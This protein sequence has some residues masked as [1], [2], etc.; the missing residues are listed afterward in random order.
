MRRASIRVVSD[1]VASDRTTAPRA[2]GPAA[3][4]LPRAVAL[5]AL[6]L[7]ALA[8]MHPPAAA[9][10]PVP[11]SVQRTLTPAER[12]IFYREPFGEHPPLGLRD[13]ISQRIA[14]GGTVHLN[15]V[16]ILGDFSDRPANLVAYPP[17][18][19]DSLLFSHGVY[20]TG[21]M[22]DYYAENS[23]GR[24]VLD[25]RVLGWYRMPL[26]YEQYVAGVAG[27]GVYPFNSQGFVEDAVR[28][29]DPVVNY[30]LYDNDGGDGV[31][32]TG[33]DDTMIDLL[34][35]IHAGSGG[36]SG[37][38]AT[39]LQ[40]IA[41]GLPNPTPFDGVFANNFAIAPE[42]AHLGVYAHET[43][44][45]LGLPD[46]YDLTGNSF[47]LG[48][49]S[50]MAGGW[51]LD[52]ARTP[53]QLDA[54]SKNLLRFNP[55]VNLPVS[56]DDQVL[57]PVERGGRIFRAWT[58]GQVG[59][60]YFLVE[61]RRRIG[62]DRF[63]P[64][65]GLL[66]YHVNEQR[67]TNNVPFQYHVALEQADGLFQLENAGHG[68]SFGDDGDPWTPDSPSGGFGRFTE[69]G[70]RTSDGFDTGVTIYHIRGPE[71]DGRMRADFRVSA[72]ATLGL[73]GID[74]P[75]VEGNGDNLITAG[76]S[77]EI[78]PRLNI[79]G[80]TAH[81]VVM[82]IATSDP[83]ASLASRTLELGDL[84]PGVHQS[85]GGFN[86]RVGSGAPQNP[87][88]MNFT[89]KINYRDEVALARPLSVAI[90]DSVGLVDT[91]ENGLNGWT[92]ESPRQ[93][94]FDLWRLELSGGNPASPGGK[95]RAWHC[96][97]TTMGFPGS[98]DAALTSPLFILPPAP[99]LLF[100]QLVEIPAGDSNQVVAGGFVE[101]SINGSNWQLITP[102]GG[103]DRTYFGRD[104]TLNRTPVFTG[105]HGTPPAWERADFNL[106]P[107]AGGVRLRFRFFAVATIFIGK[108]WWL[109][110]LA[111]V[112]GETPLRL[113]AFTATREVA[114]VRLGWR[115][116]GEERPVGY[117]ILR[118][119]T[120]GGLE[121]RVNATLI[122]GTAREFVDA[123]PPAGGAIY[124]LEAVERGGARVYLGTLAVAGGARPPA[125]RLACAPNPAPGA[126]RLTFELAE[127]GPARLSVFDARGRL[128]RTLLDAP[129]AA[130]TTTVEWDGRDDAGLVVSAGLY[131]TRLD[132][133]GGTETRKVVMAR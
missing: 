126:T 74:L 54:W 23:G 61:N 50:L 49:W 132:G 13:A 93:G 19:F 65:E 41:F 81:G 66:I 128:V 77:F 115:L 5:L 87:Y 29:A 104:E 107:F 112:N 80:G 59:P 63:L 10:P 24:L 79:S 129:A 46:L 108:G 9:V 36:E 52:E 32:D 58:N 48:T 16:V 62:F 27:R 109:D 91:F 88:G 26:R 38:S 72:G 133:P 25:G 51:S 40:S 37:A 1:R 84:A 100:D 20:P 67:G 96:G 83:L 118:T 122:P 4:R 7:A 34:L 123:A 86:V 35:C 21:S 99:H 3:A 105:R 119:D 53:A 39:N 113:A 47:G 57:D 56:L 64:G 98:T 110:N 12:D 42:D 33:D 30:A 101:A 117:N 73:D 103:Y 124:R 76:E 75:P 68:P 130:G 22:A 131:F 28:A 85:P 102:V 14:A 8:G 18:H 90:G 114:G 69:P 55:A 31:P 70:S 127:A 125:P 44:H 71:A 120:D 15:M 94:F 95:V 92:H 60:E 97:N 43:G 82:E 111:I 17:A 121:T 11:G 116:A 106:A 2:Q 6:L 45:L 78:R 89:L